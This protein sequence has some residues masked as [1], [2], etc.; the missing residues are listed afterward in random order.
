MAICYPQLVTSMDLL[1]ST[2]RL[3]R[4]GPFLA[5]QGVQLAALTNSTLYGVQAFYK[6]IGSQAC[7]L[8]ATVARVAWMA[9]ILFAAST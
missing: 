7:S 4:L 6:E 3:D 9:Y 1:Q 2:I 8:S 5:G